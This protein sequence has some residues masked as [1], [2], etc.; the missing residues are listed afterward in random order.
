MVA[1]IV[2]MIFSPLIGAI[3]VSLSEKN[4]ETAMKLKI[5][6]DANL[7][8][9]DEYQNSLRKLIPNQKDQ[10]DTNRGY[11]AIAAIIVLLFILIRCVN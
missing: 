6:R 4:T 10:A 7:I 2:S 11:L 3:V 5:S 9:E 1:L 8:T